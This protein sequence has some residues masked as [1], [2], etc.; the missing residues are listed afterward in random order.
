LATAH[1]NA[2]G[3][4]DGDATFII[5]I[6]YCVWSI[7]VGPDLGFDSKKSELLGQCT[8]YQTKLKLI[9]NY[10]TCMASKSIV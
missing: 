9:E 2:I 1:K 7:V 6:Q 8:G 10:I 4:V 3:E 5:L